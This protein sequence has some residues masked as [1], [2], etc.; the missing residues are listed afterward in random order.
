MVVA[1]EQELRSPEV[2]ASILVA[3]PPFGDSR[4]IQDEVSAVYAAP[5]VQAF[6]R[7]ARCR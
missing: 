5:F 1:S 2:L 4:Y 6:E 3:D 7:V